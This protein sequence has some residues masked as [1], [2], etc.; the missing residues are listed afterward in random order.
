MATRKV[1]S[2]SKPAAK[3]SAAVQSHSNGAATTSNGVIEPPIMP[4]YEEIR[5]RAYELY[6]A[7]GGAHGDDWNDWFVAEQELS[8]YQLRSG[9]HCGGGRGKAR[10]GERPGRSRV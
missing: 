1:K 8:K 10:A 4:S 9:Q 3:K 6:L 5:V 7:R 2:A